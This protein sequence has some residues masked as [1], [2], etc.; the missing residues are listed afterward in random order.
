[1]FSQITK[2]VLISLAD[3]VVH[4]L[5]NGINIM[6]WWKKQKCANNFF[7]FFFTFTKNTNKLASSTQRFIVE[8]QKLYMVIVFPD[9][10]VFVLIGFVLVIVTCMDPAFECTKHQNDVTFCAQ[11][12]R[13]AFIYEH[14]YTCIQH[15]HILTH[16]SAQHG[17][18]LW[19]SDAIR[20][21]TCAS[22]S[23]NDSIC[24]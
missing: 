8:W 21:S 4:F 12:N 20:A 22:L 7:F 17:L 9:L 24:F 1:M 3:W 15:S 16:L 13:R 23:S 2:Y 14:K 11:I 6:S 10:T 19:T 5:V 18:V